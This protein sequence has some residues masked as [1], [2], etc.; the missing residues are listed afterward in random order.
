L[1]SQGTIVVTR[2]PGGPLTASG[3]LARA[4][5][6][7]V[8]GDDGAGDGIF[9]GWRWNDT[10]A[11]LAIDHD[12]YG[13]YPLFGATERDRCIV[14]SDLKEVVAAAGSQAFD[15]DALAV[16]LRLGFFVGDDTPFAGVRALGPATE[17][18]WTPS[19]ARLDAIRPRPPRAT[20]LSRA[21]VVEALI[22]GVRTAIRRRVPAM[23]YD[24]PL[25]GGRDS[26][27]V[28]LALVEAGH[29]P[30]GCVTVEHYPPRG[31]DDAVV[32][33]E[34]CRRL[35]LRHLVL[36]QRVTRVRAEALKHP[37]TH[38]C[39][40]E[41]V[42]FVALADHLR[43]STRVTYDGI[44]GDVLTQSAYLSPEALASFESG[45]E[46]AA[47]AQLLD[48][49]G[50]MVTDA[51]LARLLAP[52]ILREV[53]RERAIARLVREIRMHRDAPNP[54]ASFFFWNRTRREIALAP[55]GLLRDVTV[56]AP[57][58]DRDLFD[59]MMG[60]PGRTLVDRRLHTD[61]IALAYPEVAG[62]PYATSSR[63]AGGAA[64][65]GLAIDLLRLAAATPWIRSRALA[66]AVGGA[67]VDGRGERL[68]F[69]PLVCYLAQLSGLA[70]MRARP[71]DRVA[72]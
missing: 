26:R 56:Y 62:V 41:H 63:R 44:A 57:Y 34:L 46:E 37:R 9:A 19:G 33:A 5:G 1:S 67:L 21:A 17:L 68:W 31:N 55:Y 24:L 28:L 72:R 32:A 27:H 14:S 35:G 15:F 25:S 53:P 39:T 38:Y 11:S 60:I 18:C 69:A 70:S 23:L 43:R 8:G 13:L 59:V 36:P 30:N 29:A 2:A 48:G 6:H 7:R 51:A 61:A 4:F 52:R 20:A 40:D 66:P 50:T 71:V 58:L 22:E 49:Y 3:D 45:T 16:F 47:A 54:V 10:T 42:Q 65:R 64:T 12:R